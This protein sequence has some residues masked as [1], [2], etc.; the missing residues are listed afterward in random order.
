[1]L[2]VTRIGLYWIPYERFHFSRWQV[3]GASYQ[4]EEQPSLGLGM[5]SKI[6]GYIPSCE[7]SL[8]TVQILYS[9][10]GLAGGT[11]DKLLVFSQHG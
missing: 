4:L 7:L 8:Q 10:A 1:L 9:L 3:R 2:T 5:Q 11:E 6:R